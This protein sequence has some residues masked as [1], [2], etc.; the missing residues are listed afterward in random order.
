MRKTIRGS[1][2]D[3]PK[4]YDVLFGADWQQEYDFL[5]DCFE[6]HAQRQVEYLFEPACGTGRLLIKFA[7][8]GY[9]VSGN[10]LNPKAV[11]Y[12]NARLARHEFPPAVVVG[13][14]AD[15]RRLSKGDAAFNTINS[16]RHL[17]SEAKAE[18]HLQCVARAL[19][20]GGLYVLGLHLT[21]MTP[22]ACTEESWHAQRG[23]L[24][25]NSRMKSLQVDRRRRQ[26][27]V[28]LE[29]DVSTPTQRFRLKD[30][31]IF[32]TYTGAQMHRLLGRIRDLE[33]VETYDFNYD[34]EAPI[35]VNRSTEDVVYVLRKT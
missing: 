22:Q 11:E 27:P 29:L 30:E 10:D 13:D 17:D 3:Y 19:A 33:L 35:R 26:E 31:F 32:W 14:M 8:A 4:Y 16:F 34:L 15:F 21:P 2:Y 28:S 9:E 18:S 1:V 12:C 25:V 7:Q 20:K 24:I 6:Q 5:L 23:R